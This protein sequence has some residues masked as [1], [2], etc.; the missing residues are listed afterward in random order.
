MLLI[1]KFMVSRAIRKSDDYILA[2]CQT[3][4]AQQILSRV[5]ARELFLAE[6]NRSELVNSA[7]RNR[8]F[9]SRLLPFS[10]H[11]LI[12][13]N[14]EEICLRKQSCLFSNL[15]HWYSEIV[16]RRS[17]PTFPVPSPLL[18]HTFPL[19]PMKISQAEETFLLTKIYFLSFVHESQCGVSFRKFPENF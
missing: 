4:F 3:S 2:F 19:D 12:F 11:R 5:F 14:L 1:M 16:V 13:R 18:R 6:I 10:D 17:S 7:N 15:C 8:R 9:Y